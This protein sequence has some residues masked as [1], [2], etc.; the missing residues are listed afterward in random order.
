MQAGQH[1]VIIIHDVDI[2]STFFAS[3]WGILH[4]SLWEQRMFSDIAQQ[5]ILVRYLFKQTSMN[6]EQKTFAQQLEPRS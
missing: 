2:Q 5:A 3:G 6:I 4:R 1:D